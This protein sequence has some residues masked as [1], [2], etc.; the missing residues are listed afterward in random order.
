MW[1]QSVGNKFDLDIRFIIYGV[2]TVLLDLFT[3]LWY[4]TLVVK[5]CNWD[6]RPGMWA[7]TKGLGREQ[8][9]LAS[10]VTPI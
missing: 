8:K 10:G 2:V 6:P 1:P 5:P 3:R 4:V 7:L 9:V